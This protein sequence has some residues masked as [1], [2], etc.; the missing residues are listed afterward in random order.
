MRRPYFDEFVSGTKTIEF[1]R[2]RR[3][4]TERVYY[5]GRRVVITF[6][7]NLAPRLPAIV[8]RFESKPLIQV[9]DM[10]GFYSDME[11]LDEVALIHLAISDEDRE[12]THF[13]LSQYVQRSAA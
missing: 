11:M 13:A 10:I 7:Y 3:P 2:H 8:V 4:F 1:R 6:R 9:P 12:L 5:P